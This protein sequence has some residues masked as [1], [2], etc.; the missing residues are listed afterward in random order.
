MGSMKRDVKNKPLPGPEA[1][2]I[3][4]LLSSPLAVDASLDRSRGFALAFYPIP[5]VSFSGGNNASR[6]LKL[7]KRNH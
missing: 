1:E 3:F 5:A 4:V 6:V 2:K 7:G